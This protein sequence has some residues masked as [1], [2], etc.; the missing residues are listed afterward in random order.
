M[1]YPTSF[2]TTDCVIRNQANDQFLLG[3]KKKDKGKFRFFGGFVDV[4]DDSLEAS[5]LRER[6]EEAGGDLECTPPRYIFSKRID[7]PRYRDSEHKILTA[8]F[9]SEYI[10]GFAKAGDDIDDGIEWFHAYLIRANYKDLIV[11]THWPIVEKL[12]ELRIL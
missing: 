1:D 7:D 11:E 6:I 10:F 4:K 2:Q 9:L 8:V 12:I 5:N 3:R